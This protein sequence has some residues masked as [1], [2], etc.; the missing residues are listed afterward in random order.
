MRQQLVYGNRS[1]LCQVYGNML[2]V[3]QNESL[4]V[5]LP[6]LSV[7][8]DFYCHLPILYLSSHTPWQP[9][10]AL[11][12]PYGHTNKHN[13]QS[14]TYTPRDVGDS[15]SWRY[16]QQPISNSQPRAVCL[17]QTDTLQRTCPK[18][19]K[20]T[21]FIFYFH[22]Y[23]YFSLYCVF[24]WHLLNI[25]ATEWQDSQIVWLELCV[26]IRSYR[27]TEIVGSPSSLNTC[28]KKC[29]QSKREEGK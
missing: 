8:R 5:H 29:C 6:A 18:L 17:T 26:H 19:I 13:N 10:G 9:R 7:S 27:G 25:K 22:F 23:I 1:S 11:F 12:C 3:S 20:M 16:V 15:V 4:C 28:D 2:Y 21:L 24:F 14:H